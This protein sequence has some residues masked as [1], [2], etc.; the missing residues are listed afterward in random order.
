MS[1]FL[2]VIPEG[3]TQLDWQY[4][5]NNLPNMGYLQAMDKINNG[6]I[7][8]IDAALKEYGVLPPEVTVVA[9]KLIDDTYFLVQLG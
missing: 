3:W 4:I 8:D 2:L 9:V 1:E 7:A 5:T 6:G